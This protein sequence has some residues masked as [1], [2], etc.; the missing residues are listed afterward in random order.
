MPRLRGSGKLGTVR[1]LRLP[2]PLDRWF[3]QRLCEER[4]RSASDL[5]VEAVHGGLR[6]RPGYMIRHRRTLEQQIRNGDRTLY[7]TY[8]AALDDAF[9][10]AYIQHIQA[11]LR[12]DG[13]SIPDAW[14]RSSNLARP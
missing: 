3:E 12:A 8:V 2:L 1:S 7:E 6:L 10:E 4:D 11:W 9:G 13:V 5:L 14:L